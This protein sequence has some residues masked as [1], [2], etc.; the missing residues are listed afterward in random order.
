[1]S[2]SRER[3]Y[4]ERHPHPI[5]R[6]QKHMI[7]TAI[8]TSTPHRLEELIGVNGLTKTLGGRTVVDDVSFSLRRGS[9]FGLLGRRCRFSRDRCRPAEKMRCG[10]SSA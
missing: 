7:E 5:E 8:Q 4:R 1:M 6:T 3:R 10:Q 9:A 2:I